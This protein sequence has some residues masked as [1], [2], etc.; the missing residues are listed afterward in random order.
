ME[1]QSSIPTFAADASATAEWST[2]RRVLFRFAFVYL[3]LYCTASVLG[4]IDQ[5][6]VTVLGWA[7]AAARLFGAKDLSLV[8]WLGDGGSSWWYKAWQWLTPWVGEHLL[9]L[10]DP[11]TNFTNGSGDTL[12]DWLTAAC[13]ATIALI[14]AVA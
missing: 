7:Q 4:V 6:A 1:T 13:Q 11:I 2:P 8:S 14:V 3:V 5:V 10:K 12:Y 9:R